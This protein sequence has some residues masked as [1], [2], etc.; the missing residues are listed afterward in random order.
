MKILY[1]TRDN[2]NP[3]PI[4]LYWRGPG[5][6]SGKQLHRQFAMTQLV[7]D[8]DSPPYIAPSMGVSN[9]EWL[10]E[11]MQAWNGYGELIGSHGIGPI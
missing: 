8:L 6:Y 4:C 10:D 3:Y 11:P 5:W 7:G 2:D 1:N 9:P